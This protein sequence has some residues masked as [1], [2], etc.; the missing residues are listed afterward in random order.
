MGRSRILR[1][2]PDD[3]V[4]RVGTNLLNEGGVTHNVSKVVS[5]A[6]FSKYFDLDCD[7]ALLKVEN[8]FEIGPMVKPIPLA[9]TPL[10]SSSI[11][12]VS[13]WGT[14]EEAGDLANTLLKV[15]IPVVPH[16][17][18]KWLYGANKISENMF[19]GGRAG[20]DSCQGD[21]GGPVVSNGI[22]IG[23][24]SWGEGCAR[25]GYPGVY[26]DVY[27]LRSWVLENSGV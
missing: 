16:W 14:T 2:D 4:V 24:V 20:K 15:E 5:H 19:C 17:E 27:K 10:K 25:P 12:V 8:P 13:G 22:L 23:V 26:A 18:C 21:S 9:K 6:D 1:S 3:L 11:I 7:M